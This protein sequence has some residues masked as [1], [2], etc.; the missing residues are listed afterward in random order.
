M[1][2]VG[3]GGEEEKDEMRQQHKQ[4]ITASDEQG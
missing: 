4:S 2:K 3:E 1:K